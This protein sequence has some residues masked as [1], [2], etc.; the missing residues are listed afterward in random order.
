LRKICSLQDRAEE[1][2][3]DGVRKIGGRGRKEGKK[4]GKGKKEEKEKGKGGG[5]EEGGGGGVGGGGVA[6]EV[7]SQVCREVGGAGGGG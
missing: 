4:R 2:C 3:K 5:G 1:Q 7:D 6:F